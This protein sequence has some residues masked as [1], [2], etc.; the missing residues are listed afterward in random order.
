MLGGPVSASIR[1][2]HAKE[3]PKRTEDIPCYG[4][5]SL[6]SPTKSQPTLCDADRSEI[7]LTSVSIGA[8]PKEEPTARRRAV[9]GDARR[10]V[11]EEENGAR[12]GETE[13]EDDG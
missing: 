12:T 10:T 3:E 4:K 7:R 1:S 2:G 13:A 5:R 8:F 11:E 6:C 9:A